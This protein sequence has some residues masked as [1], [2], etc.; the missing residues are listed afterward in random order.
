MDALRVLAVFGPIHGQ[1]GGA[2]RFIKGR[3]DMSLYGLYWLLRCGQRGLWHNES[4]L[5]AKSEGKKG[6]KGEKEKKEWG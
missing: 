3:K 5:G 2:P 1:D 6:K 4:I